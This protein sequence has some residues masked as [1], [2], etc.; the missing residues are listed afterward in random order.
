VLLTADRCPN[1]SNYEKEQRGVTRSR[2]SLSEL[3]HSG[4]RFA[5]NLDRQLR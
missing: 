5:V 1:N 3:G 2:G 4:T